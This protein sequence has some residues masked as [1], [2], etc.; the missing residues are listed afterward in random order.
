VFI[1][2]GLPDINKGLAISR[3]PVI[4]VAPRSRAASTVCTRWFATGESMYGTPR[5]VEHD[6]LGSIGPM[7]RSSCSVSWRARCGSMTPMIGRISSTSHLRTGVDSSRIAS[8]CWDD[9]RSR[10]RTKPTATVAAMRLAAG[11]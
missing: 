8:R 9:V 4:T 3:E 11:S 6:D 7:P 5:D 2:P 1:F 10:S